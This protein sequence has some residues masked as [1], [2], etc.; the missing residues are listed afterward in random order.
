MKAYTRVYMQFFGYTT[1]DWM[2]CE[3]PGCGQRAVDVCHIRAKSTRD[4]LRNDIT[5]LMGKCREHHTEYGD[6]VQHRAFLQKAHNAFMKKNGKP[7]LDPS[8]THIAF[9]GPPSAAL[10]AAINKMV[11][12]AKTKK[13]NKKNS[14]K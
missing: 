2:P 1:A 8:I 13:F 4:D 7:K 11:A 5:N 14:T 12:I 10:V 6:K 9:S 3:I